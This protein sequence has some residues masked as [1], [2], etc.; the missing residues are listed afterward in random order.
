[1]LLIGYKKEIFRPECNPVFQSLHCFV[2]LEQDVSAV[3]PYLNATLGG[4]GYTADPPSLL[5]RVHGKLITI[6][7]RKIAINALK[8]EAEAEKI[9]SWLQRE[10]NKTWENK[11]AIKACYAVPEKPRVIDVLKRL[12]KTNCRQCGQATCIVFSSLV[13]IGAKS[14]ADCPTITRANRDQLERHLNRFQFDP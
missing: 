9:A 5:L 14:P 12:P 7:A 4:S 3:L 8:D 13:V 11:D 2:Y 1:M 6:H 10:I